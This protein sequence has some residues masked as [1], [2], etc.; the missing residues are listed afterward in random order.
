MQVGGRDMDFPPG[1]KCGQKWP[2]YALIVHEARQQQ[3]WDGLVHGGCYNYGVN[4]IVNIYKA[5]M[6][7][8]EFA[9]RGSVKTTTVRHYVRERLLTPKTGLVGGSRPYLDFTEADLKLLKAIQAGQA[10]GMSLLEIRTLVAERR[11]GNGSSR[12]LKALVQHR[13]KLK[14]RAVDLQ[15]MLSFLERKIEWLEAG[16]KGPAPSHG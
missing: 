2:P 5:V 11:S 4:Y 12:M 3:K 7:I 13:E 8:A 9:S 1:T 14:R 15:T 6:W 16:S 10:L